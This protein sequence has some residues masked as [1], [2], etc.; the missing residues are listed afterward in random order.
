MPTPI[1]ILLDPVS[2]GVLAL[3]GAMMLWESTAP[4]R[5]LAKVR[6]WLPR[7]LGSFAVYFYLSSYLPLIWDGYLAQYQLF[8]L[9]GLGTVAGAAIGVLVYEGLV[10]PVA[11]VDGCVNTLVF[12]SRHIGESQVLNFLA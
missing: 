1:E 8:D 6:G 7:A 5:R 10:V 2:L 3:Y 9:S 11:T 4:G 12:L